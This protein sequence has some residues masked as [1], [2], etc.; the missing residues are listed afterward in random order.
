MESLRNRIKH[1]FLKQIIF[2]LDFEGLLEKDVEEC[3]FELRQ[4]FYGAG[5]THMN[6]RTENQADIQIKIDLN[7]SSENEYS[8]NSVNEGVVYNFSSDVN[9]E[10]E[11]S[12]NFFTLTIDA[13]KE[14]KTFDKYISLLSDSIEIIKS[15]S[16]YFRALRMGLRKINIC[17]LKE[18][19]LTSSFFSKAAFNVEELRHQFSDFDCTGSNMV[20]LFVNDGY[21]I[22]YVRNIQ[23]GAMQQEDGTQDTVY[24]IA[25][26]ID[27]YRESDKELKPVLSENKSIETTLKEQNKVEFEMFIKSLTNAMIE[28]MTEDDFECTEI[29]GV[30]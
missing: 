8:V 15:S 5:F 25:L 28:K 20:T 2:R 1:H 23:K 19:D 29:L 12:K 9:E 17:F 26:D 30:N 7:V 27:V 4:K 11:L 3:V 24:Q 16:P 14:Y 6:R 21:C 13:D 22:N 18:L 10:I